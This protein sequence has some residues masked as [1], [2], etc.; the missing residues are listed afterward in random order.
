MTEWYKQANHQY[1]QTIV[2]KSLFKAIHT[3]VLVLVLVL[4]GEKDMNAPLNTVI[5]AYKML[6]WQSFQEP[7]ILLSLPISMLS[8]RVSRLFWEVKKVR[9][10]LLDVCQLPETK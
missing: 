10:V 1:D 3:P 8:G 6:N 7:H 5:A 4:A 9:A 2:G